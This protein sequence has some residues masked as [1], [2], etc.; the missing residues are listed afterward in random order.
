MFF[1]DDQRD[2]SELGE[3]P[4]LLAA[5]N[6]R[7]VEILEGSKP[8]GEEEALAQALW[9]LRF[10]VWDGALFGSWMDRFVGSVRE[11]FD[12]TVWEATNRS[13]G[14]TP[15]IEQLYQGCGRLPEG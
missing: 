9:D 14:I 6:A 13:R 2:E 8:G 15:D 4:E 10:Q 11:H 3:Q 5:S 1:R 7:L 12:S